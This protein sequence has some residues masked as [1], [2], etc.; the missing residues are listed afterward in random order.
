MSND[1]ESPNPNT[2]DK[3][4]WKPGDVVWTKRPTAA[5]RLANKVTKHKSTP[6][7]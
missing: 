1:D 2:E 7:Q 4:T 5:Q 6:P 3:M